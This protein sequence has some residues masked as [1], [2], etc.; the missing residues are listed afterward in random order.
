M[1]VITPACSCF[2]HFFSSILSLHCV[3]SGKRNCYI[4]RTCFRKE[5][6]SVTTRQRCRQCS[7]R[8]MPWWPFTV[9][10]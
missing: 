5:Q 4:G 10:E 7:A 6:R 8:I 9:D 2:E 1:L 3:V